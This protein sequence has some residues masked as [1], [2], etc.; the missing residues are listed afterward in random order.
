VR[1]R[2]E[3]MTITGLVTIARTPGGK[4]EAGDLTASCE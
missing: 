3:G 1:A 4:A 2:F